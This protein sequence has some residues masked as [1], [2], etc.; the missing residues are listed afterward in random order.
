M[1]KVGAK[2]RFLKD[3]GSQI[4][5]L[6]ILGISL[7]LFLGVSI[8]YLAER[9]VPCTTC[10]ATRQQTNTWQTSPHR[11]VPCLSCHKDP[12]Y[13]S[14]VNL[15]LRVAKNSTAWLFRAYQ[16]P[17]TARVKNENCLTCHEREIKDTIL[18]KGIRVS[19]K[20]FSTYLCTDC[21]ASVAHEMKNRVRNYPDMDSCANCHNYAEGDVACEKCHPKNSD[22]EKLSSRGPW[23]I[24]HGPD[25]Q[26]THGM[27][28][29]KTCQTCHDAYFCMSCHRSEVPHTKP[30]S[31][32]H[33]AAA[34]S[35][36]DGCYQ[37]HRKSYCTDCHRLQM[38]HP[39]GFLK[40]HEFVVEDKGYDVCWRC[41]VQ[42]ACISCH[43]KAAHP[44]TPSKKFAPGSR[45]LNEA[46]VFGNR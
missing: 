24:S 10:H 9:G 18:G 35:N 13:F 28:D 32:L 39:E 43:M 3:I 46:D 4:K 41:H 21:H 15:Q 1:V 19:H 14:F 17:I 45:Q 16:D 8:E 34:K 11:S 31:Y 5:A 38:P 27:G 12:G 40:E 7:F 42:D 26:A 36:V 23:K 22:P 37:C 20:E 2:G 25:W 29:P 6:I 30:W 44:N 33:P